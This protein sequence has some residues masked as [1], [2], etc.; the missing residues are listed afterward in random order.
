MNIA[1]PPGIQLADTQRRLH[2]VFTDPGLRR[3]EIFTGSFIPGLLQVESYTRSLLTFYRKIISVGYS[4]DIEARVQLRQAEQQALLERQPPLERL[5]FII[6]E[7]AI[8]RLAAD[9][10]M[11]M[12]QCSHL[13]AM[14]QRPNVY[15]YL[16][17]AGR[18]QRSEQFLLADGEGETFA[19]GPAL[20]Q[21]FVDHDRIYFGDDF[22][23]DIVSQQQREWDSELEAAIDT[24]T[25]RRFLTD[26]VA[27]RH[28]V[29]SLQSRLS[30]INM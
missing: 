30:S 8:I 12:E 4:S 21:D 15:I 7:K 1:V 19:N 6:G 2:S 28:T 24:E 14:M 11:L 9:P 3:I 17:P 27:G 25:T 16:S 5:S 29:A 13:L 18:V 23:D 20:Y 26:I 10:D 22:D